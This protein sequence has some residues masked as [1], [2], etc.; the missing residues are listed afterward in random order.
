MTTD[1][2]LPKT[3]RNAV[4]LLVR[5]EQISAVV[6]SF[7]ADELACGHDAKFGSAAE[8]RERTTKIPSDVTCKDCHA[9]ANP[10][11]SMMG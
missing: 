4:H 1:N 9:H 3:S 2:L 6:K 8:W 7:W 11:P 5:R 10:R